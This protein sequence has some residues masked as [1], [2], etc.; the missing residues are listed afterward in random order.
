MFI[1]SEPEEI[2]ER[3]KKRRTKRRRL[4]SRTSATEI[5]NLLTKDDSVIARMLSSPD[6]LI[7]MCMRKD[8]FERAHQVIKMFNMA[9][10]P[11]AQA[12]LFA[13]K[14]SKSVKHLE[15]LQ[16]KGRR[17]MASQGL[18]R[19]RKPMGALGAVAM[20]AASGS[21]TSQISKLI[22]D[23]LTTPSL[24]AVVNPSLN[25]EDL[26]SGNSTLVK[27]LNPQMVPAM[28]CI[29]MAST[30]EVSWSVC[31]TLL[32]M[33]KSRLTEGKMIFAGKASKREI[34]GPFFSSFNPC[35]SLQSVATDGGKQFHCLSMALNNKN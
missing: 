26:T 12:A 10:K 20:A 7:Y 32:E 17:I 9:Q 27:Y 28:L 25:P 18:S 6:T 13:E 35:P 23:L 29:D 11:S 21:Y 16:P 4:T 31:K 24:A 2:K 3:V 30:A 14:Y 34:I 5:S 19:S 33:A 1:F 22:D 15:S 8:N